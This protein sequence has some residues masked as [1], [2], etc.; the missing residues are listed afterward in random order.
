MVWGEESEACGPPHCLCARG[1]PSWVWVCFQGCQVECLHCL[2]LY[3]THSSLLADLYIW[4]EW[5][6]W[7]RQK[8]KEKHKLFTLHLGSDECTH[9]NKDKPYD[10]KEYLS[11]PSSTVFFSEGL[12]SIPSAMPYSQ[13]MSLGTSEI[14]STSLENQSYHQS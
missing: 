2:F 14:Q 5:T 3:W 9:Q 4:T 12:Y 6:P 8:N 11:S 13:L 7:N 1:R 10:V